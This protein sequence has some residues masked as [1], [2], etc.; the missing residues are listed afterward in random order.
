[1]AKIVIAEDEKDIRNLVLFT[2]QLAG[3][4]VTTAKNGEEAIQKIREVHPDLILLDVRMPKM[5]GYEACE[6]IKKDESIKNIP[7]IF[8]SAKGQDQEIETGLKL[9]ATKYILKPFSPD[10]LTNEVK[11]ILEQTTQ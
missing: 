10:K 8:L 11:K 3:H 4:E 7:L 9:G 6:E 5:T 2:L 1:M